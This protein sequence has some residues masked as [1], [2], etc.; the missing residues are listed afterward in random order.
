MPKCDLC[1]KEV[2]KVVNIPYYTDGDYYCEECIM[3]LQ[4]RRD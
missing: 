4:D 1:N 3:N 2:D